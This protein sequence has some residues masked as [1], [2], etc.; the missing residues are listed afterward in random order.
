MKVNMTNDDTGEVKQCKVGF[1]WT[2]FF[3]GFLVPIF[4]GD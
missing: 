1:S 2:M 3:F 4:R